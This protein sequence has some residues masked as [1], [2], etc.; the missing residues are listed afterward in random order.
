MPVVVCFELIQFV[1][2]DAAFNW[3]MSCIVG[4]L[5]EGKGK[6]GHGMLPR[7]PSCGSY[8]K[9]EIGKLSRGWKMIVY[10]K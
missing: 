6:T 9:E 5:E 8:G 7:W 4:P 10:K 1:A 3:M 2:G